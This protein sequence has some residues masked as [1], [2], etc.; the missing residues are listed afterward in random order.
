M[1]NENEAFAGGKMPPATAAKMAA[2]QVS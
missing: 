1:L 2:L